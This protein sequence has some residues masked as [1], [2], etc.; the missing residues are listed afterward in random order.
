[1][2]GWDEHFFGPDSAGSWGSHNS[3][4]KALAWP[5]ER[6]PLESHGAAGKPLISAC[7][8]Q[9]ATAVRNASVVHGEWECD[10][11]DFR[12]CRMQSL[13]FLLP[14]ET[15]V[16]PEP[17]VWQNFFCSHLIPPDIILLHIPHE[18]ISKTKSKDL[19]SSCI[20]SFATT[21]HFLCLHEP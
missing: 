7:A 2:Q 6:D 19:Q 4:H 9:L 3:Q 13:C 1:M 18:E 17:A 8:C 11:E 14:P 16:A 20:K 5:A 15:Y 21:K 12:A 10:K